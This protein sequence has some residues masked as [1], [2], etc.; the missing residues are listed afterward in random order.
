MNLR[1]CSSRHAEVKSTTNCTL[2]RLLNTQLGRCHK[3]KPA[4][5][6]EKYSMSQHMLLHVYSWFAWMITNDYNRFCPSR[7]L[8]RR[9]FVFSMRYN[10]LIHNL[11]KAIPWRFHRHLCR[12]KDKRDDVNLLRTYGTQVCFCRTNTVWTVNSCESAFFHPDDR[13]YA[14]F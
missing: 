11:I 14:R 1:I 10:W 5:K 7:S 8:D 13:N 2:D 6:M 3:C 9:R 4:I 12:D